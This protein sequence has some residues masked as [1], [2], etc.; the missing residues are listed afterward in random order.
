MF[1]TDSFYFLILIAL[2]FLIVR[3]GF[4]AKTFDGIPKILFNLCIP[5]VILISF[6]DLDSGL[7]QPDL[8]LVSIFAAAYTLSIY[9]LAHL[10]LRRYQNSARKEPLI[11]N[12][13]VGNVSFVGLPFI[14]YFF[15]APGV[16]LAIVFGVVQD[17]FIWSLCYY[18]FAQKGGLKQAFKTIL[19]PCFVAVII[20]FFLAGTGASL[21]TF[22]QTPAHM[23]ADAMIPLALL[24]IGGLL[25]Q[26]TDALTKIDRDAVFSVAIKTF[27]LPAAVFALLTVLGV[28]FPLALFCGFITAL[29]VPLLSVLFSK[30]FG[31][32]VAFANVVFVLSTLTFILAC[33]A[34]FLLQARGFYIF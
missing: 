8:F 5:A 33:I 30:E 19:N 15:G 29:P 1:Q 13:I 27:L 3:M 32:D 21:P 4:N 9:C 34:L 26:N 2:A 17:F 11:F 28:A 23:L 10:A 6:S 22:V 31:K 14:A 18:M 7:S 24:F 20:G 25:A 12:M 16:R